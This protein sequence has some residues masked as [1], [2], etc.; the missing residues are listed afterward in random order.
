M[1]AQAAC[2]RFQIVILRRAAKNNIAT[3]KDRQFT[4]PI[5]GQFQFA[6]GGVP[7]VHLRDAGQIHQ[8]VA[9]GFDGLSRWQ[10]HDGKRAE[11]AMMDHVRIGDGQNHAKP[12]AEFFHQPAFEVNHVGRTVRLL[13]RVHAVIGRDAGDGA[14]FKQPPDFH[15]NG[16][17]K[18][19]HFGRRRRI[20]VLQ[21]VRRGEVKEVGH[22][23][24]QQRDAGPEDIKAGLAA[25]DGRGGMADQLF[26][27]GNTVGLLLR[28]VRFLGGEGDSA[29]FDQSAGEDVA[30]LFLGG[31]HGHFPARARGGG[32]DRFATQKL[33]RVH[34]HFPPADFLIEII[35]PDAMNGRRHAGDDG[36]VV[37]V[38]ERR[39]R[40]A[41][42]AAVAAHAE[43]LQVRHPAA[44]DRGI[45]IFIGRAVQTNDHHRT[46]R[47]PIGTAIDG[48]TFRA[49]R[50]HRFQACRV[51]STSPMHS[52]RIDS[53]WS[54]SDREIVSAGVSVR[55]LPI[56]TLKFRPRR[57]A[58]Y[59]TRSASS[60]AHSSVPRRRNNSM[61]INRPSPRTSPMSG[62]RPAISRRRPSA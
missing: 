46:R 21:I 28:L 48:K 29:L 43:A 34:H 57:S 49:D 19:H 53:A 9:H 14:E 8:P 47:R 37:D 30:Q 52:S 61:P 17:V 6:R 22:P 59:I 50:A 60:V 2:Q 54:S 15:V 20:L 27:P 39:H 58:P 45:E 44:R 4:Q 35:P 1:R 55:R 33:R 24:L 38:G 56:V 31:D 40:A 7:I 13:F 3:G 11:R 32:K 26:N 36:A 51:P 10:M 23:V 41:R 62:C 5:G 18:L 42:Q 25:V 12:F 16:G